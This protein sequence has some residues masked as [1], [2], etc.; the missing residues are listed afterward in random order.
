M[1]GGL[2]GA[3]G[4]FQ[5]RA[6]RRAAALQLGDIEPAVQRAAL[7]CLTVRSARSSR[8][9]QR[10]RLTLLSEMRP[11]VRDDMSSDWCVAFLFGQAM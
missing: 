9:L 3:K 2:K 11:V 10:L 5:W 8:L 4:L 6:V 1:V 7:Q